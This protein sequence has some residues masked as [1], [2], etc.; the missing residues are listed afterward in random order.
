[1]PS[2]LGELLAPFIDTLSVTAG[3]GLSQ[4]QAAAF[5]GVIDVFQD[6]L[7]RVGGEHLTDIVTTRSILALATAGLRG[8]FVKELARL[9]F[10]VSAGFEVQ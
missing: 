2:P 6:A 8:Q 9:M 10:F 4:T 5:S 7:S 1:M 3:S